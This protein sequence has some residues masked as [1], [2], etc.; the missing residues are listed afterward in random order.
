[1]IKNTEANANIIAFIRHIAISGPTLNC[2]NI[3]AIKPPMV[4]RELDAI[5]G[6]ALLN[7]TITASFVGKCSCSSL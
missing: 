4:V 3:M 1:M 2:M 6:I 7:A 5:S